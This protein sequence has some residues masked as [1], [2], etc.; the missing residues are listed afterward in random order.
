MSTELKILEDSIKDVGYWSWWTGDPASAIQIEFGGT[1][2]WSKPLA[3]GKPP[4]SQIAL[5]FAEPTF[6]AFLSRAGE[7]ADPPPTAWPDLMQTDQLGNVGVDEDEFTFTDPG[8]LNTFFA[9]AS[10]ADVRVGDSSV[11]AAIPND[12][13]FAGFWAGSIGIIVVAARMKVV[14]HE[15]EIPLDRIA[16]MHNRWWEYWKEYWK[17]KDTD[18]PM[19]RDYACEVTI[20]IGWE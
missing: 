7:E 16:G 8:R 1:Q 3:E 4:N 19:P 13:M 20:P 17:S 10:H 15:G 6:V 12:A 5:R 11:L 9:H 2:L 14:N 18:T